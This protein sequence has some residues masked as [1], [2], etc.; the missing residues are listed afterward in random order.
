MEKKDVRVWYHPEL[1]TLEVRWSDKDGAYAST[2][3][4]RVMEYVTDSGE[5]LGFMIE[6]VGDIGQYETVSF[7]VGANT[8]PRLENTTVAHAAE[9][10]N[11]TEGRV[12]QL[13]AARRIKGAYRAGRDWLIPLPIE[14]TP[15]A[16]GREGVAGK[17]HGPSKASA[18]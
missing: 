17:R 9:I 8:S 11:V 10:L 2:A 7:Q 14:M 18:S 15:G 4:E 5:S 1:D 6:G 13:C 12:R 16:R 3:D